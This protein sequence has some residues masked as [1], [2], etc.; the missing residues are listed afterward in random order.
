MK[1]NT[2]LRY[3]GGKTKLFPILSKLAEPYINKGVNYCEPFVGGGGVFV[4]FLLQDSFKHYYINDLDPA[5]YA[6]WHTVFTNADELCNYIETCTIS[7]DERKRCLEVFNSPNEFSELDVACA[8]LFLNRVNRSGV[9]TAG[10]IGGN[11]QTG[12]YKMDCRFNRSD[13][14]VKILKL[15]QFADKVT[16]TNEDIFSYSFPT[17]SFIYLD[18]PYVKAGKDCYRCSFCEE[19]HILLKDKLTLVDNFWIMSY[20]DNSFIRSLYEKQFSIIE[21]ELSYSMA[22]KRKQTELIIVNKLDK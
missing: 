1:T 20:D 14:V 15:S 5:L 22:Q 7:L 11:A 2:P 9:F 21:Q 12:N 8:T 16:V 10:V 19:Q 3:A 18:P 6:F 17:N 4:E 13:L